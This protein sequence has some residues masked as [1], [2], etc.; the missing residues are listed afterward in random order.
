MPKYKYLSAGLFTRGLLHA[1]SADECLAHLS[2]TSVQRLKDAGYKVHATVVSAPVE[3][4]IRRAPGRA[5]SSGRGMGVN[6][7]LRSHKRASDLLESILPFTDTIAYYDSKIN[8]E[9]R[10]EF[11]PAAGGILPSSVPGTSPT[12]VKIRRYFVAKERD[13]KIE[14]YRNEPEVIDRTLEVVNAVTD[15]LPQ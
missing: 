4:A 12:P 14:L 11:G 7:V 13:E 9:K 2:D 6:R 8:W 15:L 10:N 5:E 3:E 1:Y